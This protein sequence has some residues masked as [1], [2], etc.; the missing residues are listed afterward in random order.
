MYTKNQPKCRQEKAACF[1]YSGGCCVVLG[2][3]DFGERDCPF[4][5]V[6]TQ[7]EEEDILRRERLL[8]LGLK[9]R[10]IRGDGD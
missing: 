5:K 4:F 3:T 2:D 1:A 9:P 6:W 7:A 8:A 10:E